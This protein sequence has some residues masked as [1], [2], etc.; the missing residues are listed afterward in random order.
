MTLDI[1]TW[2]RL[3]T[4]STRTYSNDLCAGVICDNGDVDS[5]KNDN[6]KDGV[7]GD[8]DGYGKGDDYT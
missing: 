1:V 4:C 5:N 8:D 6:G 2:L 3:L 7:G